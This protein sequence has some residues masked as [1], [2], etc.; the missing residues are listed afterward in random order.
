MTNAERK[1]RF[2]NKLK[3]TGKFEEF[4]NK[5]AA[6]QRKRRARRNAGIE[7]LP[8]RE[9]VK[10]KRQNREEYRAKAAEYRRRQR[11]TR[12]GFIETAISVSS[13]TLDKSDDGLYKTKS[14]LAKAV[15]K[16]KRALPATTPKKK[17]VIRKIL[18]SFNSDD[19]KDILPEK[20][21]RA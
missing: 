21:D 11:E 2:I 18:Q 14:A 1:E 6:E 8:E 15:A 9:K 17:Q 13:A 4:K 19:L 20:N 10:I 12:G 16:V 5:N 3:S 7:T